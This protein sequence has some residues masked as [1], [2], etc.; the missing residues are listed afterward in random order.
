MIVG[1]VLGATRFIRTQY[2]LYLRVGMEPRHAL[3]RAVRSYFS[4]F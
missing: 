4:G 2:R 1:T 3:K